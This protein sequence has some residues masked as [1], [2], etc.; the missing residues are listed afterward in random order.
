MWNLSLSFWVAEWFNTNGKTAAAFLS[1]FTAI[2]E[3]F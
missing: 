3:T 2:V 1:L